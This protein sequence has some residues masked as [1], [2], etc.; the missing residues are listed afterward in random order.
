MNKK[1][2]LRIILSISAI[3]VLY[4]LYVF[5]SNPIYFMDY[6]F[7]LLSHFWIIAIVVVIL[8]LVT[9]FVIN[10]NRAQMDETSEVDAETAYRSQLAAIDDLDETYNAR[11]QELYKEA[12]FSEA[13]TKRFLEN[14]IESRKALV[15]WKYRMSQSG[16]LQIIEDITKGYETA[17]KRIAYIRR[18]PREMLKASDLLYKELPA[19]VKLTDELDA[20]PNQGQVLK[21]IRALSEKIAGAENSDELKNVSPIWQESSAQK[22][23]KR[24]K[25]PWMIGL[26]VLVV[27]A[28]VSVITSQILKISQNQSTNK[29]LSA[30]RV[31]EQGRNK[32]LITNW[33]LD[34]FK[35]LRVGE[36][37]GE[38]GE[39]FESL[40]KKYG[41]G[42]YAY[43][44]KDQINGESYL[45]RTVNYHFDKNMDHYVSLIFT[46]KN[47][48]QLYLTSAEEKGLGNPVGLQLWTKAVYEKIEVGKSW[49]ANHPTGSLWSEFKDKVGDPDMVNIYLVSG[50]A[51]ADEFWHD[52]QDSQKYISLELSVFSDRTTRVTYKSATATLK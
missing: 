15:T 1:N 20:S 10:R 26:L 48:D 34:D 16:K 36:I 6:L 45:T 44:G 49:D 12:N 13:D 5:I 50:R 22:L 40:Y 9:F 2:A 29:S 8:G 11:D 7:V 38:G 21:S 37:T 31:P 47:E 42:Y 4:L 14:L 46:G 43:Q 39:S 35:V 52:S 41:K 17:E 3:V 33:S 27:L 32:T 24:K 30:Y 25:N 23:S 51:Q 18:N 19:I 28:T